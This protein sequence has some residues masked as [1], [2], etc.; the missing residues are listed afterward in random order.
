MITA[1]CSVEQLRLGQILT[2]VAV[3]PPSQDVGV[4]GV[5]ADSRHLKAGDVFIAYRSTAGE[6]IADAIYHGAAAV[7]IEATQV[8]TTFNAKVPI[9]AVP[10]LRDHAG[11]IAARVL[12]HPTRDLSVVGVTGTNGKTTVS[13]LIAEAMHQ[14]G[15]RSGLAGTL[16]HG[17]WGHLIDASNTTPEAVTLQKTAADL[18]RRGVAQLVL[19]VSSHGLNEARVGGV[20]FD[21]AVFTNL[22]R[23][24]LDYHK[25]MAHYAASKRRLFSDYGVSYGIF[26]RDDPYGQQWCEA[27]CSQIEVIGYTLQADKSDRYPV[28]AGRIS[29][30][31]VAG[32]TLEITSPFGNGT[33]RT[34]LIGHFNAANLL[35][36]V[37][38]LCASKVALQDVLASL[39]ACTGV[40]G[41]MEVLHRERCPTVV[42]DYAHTPDAL[43]QALTTLR[44]L[45]KGRLFCV[46]GCGG[47]RDKGKRAEMGRIAAM[48]ADQVFLTND[49]PRGESA[50]AIITDICCGIDDSSKV[51][52]DLDRS[53]AIHAAIHMA[54]SGDIVLV[55][56]KG[57][58][59]TQA[60]AG[61]VFPWQDRQVCERALGG[62]R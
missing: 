21:G 5:S 59:T 37:A 41:R 42:V 62:T 10:M 11:M 15:W 54:Q 16:G 60:I 9:F 3:V 61:R 36:A 56:G 13:H 7:L 34:S 40:A 32:M 25:T 2:G 12:D 8:P 23:D 26:N 17:A 31:N 14:L 51:L 6:H 28:V 29:E 19:E 22:S 27:F 46:F 47:E 53:G 35:A 33:L 58:E 39:A 55:A 1:Q 44:S 49:N 30:C 4:T 38:T 43:A 45:T 18:R 20:E 24:H 57:H 50:E 48:L 52:I